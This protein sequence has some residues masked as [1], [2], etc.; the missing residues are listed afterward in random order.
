[1]TPLALALSAVAIAIAALHLLWALG[2]WWPIR[3][4]AALARAVLG[5][6]DA[7]RMPGA[8]PTALVVVA[9]MFAA[10]LPWVAPGPLRLAG[11]AALAAVFL[12]RGGAA[13]A[14]PFQA[15]TPEQPFRRLDQRVYGP[16]SLAL[17]AGYAIL[18]IGA[19]T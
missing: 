17:G 4:E 5:T 6:R 9:L 19:L 3:D 16:L 7:E 15:L 1:M 11:L 12:A 14:P 13:Y 10:A 8:V 2:Y 18:A